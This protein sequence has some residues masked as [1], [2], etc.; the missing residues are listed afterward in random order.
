M[1]SPRRILLAAEDPALR[2]FLTDNLTAD[3]YRVLVAEDKPTALHVL[4]SERPAL[5]IC[6]VNG[7]TLGLVDAVR[8]ADGLAGHV[9]PDT[10][11]MVLTARADEPARVRYLDRGSD[12]VIETPFSYPELRARLRALLRRAYERRTPRPVAVGP[13]Q[14]DPVAH[15]VTLAATPVEVSRME[16]A[17]LSALAAEPLRVFTKDELLRDVW[18]FRSPGRTRTVDSHAC[19]LRTKLAAA[20]GRGYVE[21]VWG[22]GYRLT[23]SSG[24]RE[25]A[26]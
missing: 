24:V 6:D 20:G 1:S 3:G 12:D 7:D 4:A 8:S 15:A 13:L 16:L 11:L 23:R 26:A 5:A 17:L 25:E 21:N 9:H 14:I 18:G 10:P 22:V 2:A 19:R